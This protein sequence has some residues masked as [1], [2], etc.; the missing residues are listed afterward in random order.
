MVR[1]IYFLVLLLMT[2]PFYGQERAYHTRKKKAIAFYEEA[3]QEFAMGDLNRTQNLLR[4]ALGKDDSFDEAIVLLH[5]VLLRSNQ[6]EAAAEWIALKETELTSAFANQ[7]KIDQSYYHFSDGAY[8]EAQNWMGQVAL[9]GLKDD[10]MAGVMHL[11]ANIDFSLKQVQQSREI[12][13]ETLPEPLNMWTQQYFPSVFG[14]DHLVFTVR[15]RTGRGDEDLFISWKKEVG[16]SEP[17]S[18]SDKINSQQNEGTA[19]ISADG[20]TIVFT[21]CNRPNNMGSCDLY[22]TYQE[23]G[24]WKTPELLNENV[25]SIHWDSQPSLSSDGRVLFFVSKRPGG[26]GGQDIYRSEWANGQWQPAQ[27]L[28]KP[29]NTPFDDVSPVILN[30]RATL[31]YASKGNRSMG[32]F[33]LFQSEWK[34]GN[35]QKPI[36][37][38]YPINNAYDQVGYSISHSGWAYFSSEQPDG[39]ILL[40]RFRYPQELLPEP[41]AP[42]NPILRFLNARTKTPIIKEI[43]VEEG[44]VVRRENGPFLKWESGK[45]GDFTVY[46]DGFEKQNITDMPAAGD[47][48][49]V[50]LMPVSFDES[51]L[52]EPIFFGFDDAELSPA[53]QAKLDPLAHYMRKQNHFLFEIQGHTDGVGTDAYNEKL[54]RM[55]AE[56]VKAYLLKKNV[57]K[58]NLVIRAYGKSRMLSKSYESWRQSENR[59]VEIVIKRSLTK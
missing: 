7:L 52:Q 18:I 39:R 37:L 25:N 20:K 29:I 54:S 12:Y 21:S 43:L 48:T 41:V 51:I 16:W 1:F 35:W 11:K 23:Q 42:L 8:A 6:P 26:V 17:A 38:G 49:E 4:Q 32:G 3:R 47:T 57:S 36:H 46:A 15:D 55:R 31:I 44:G 34:D 28:G 2:L 13:F 9:D 27:N 58:E 5:Q 33:D 19:S 30:E 40:S 53:A 45:T 22:I 10:E 56:K 24:H 50:G 14:D 59:R